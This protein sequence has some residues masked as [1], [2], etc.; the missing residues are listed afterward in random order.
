MI[1]FLSIFLPKKD[2]VCIFMH[3]NLSAQAAGGR[4]GGRGRTEEKVG[5]GR[6]QTQTGG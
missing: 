1:M 6:S 3:F 5:G 2:A 4:R